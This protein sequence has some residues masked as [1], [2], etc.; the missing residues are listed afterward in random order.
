MNTLAN[1]IGFGDYRT[2]IDSKNKIKQIL[3][4]E[5]QFYALPKCWRF[6]AVLGV[7]EHSIIWR[8]QSYLRKW[9]YH[10]NLHHRIRTWFYKYKTTKLGNKHHIFISPNCI[11][12]GLKIFHLGNIM[13]NGKAKIGKNFGVH[14]G[15][16]IVATNGIDKAAVIG[17][18]CR[19]G[20]GAILVG[21][22]SLGNNIVVGAGSIVTKSFNVNH[23]TLAGVPAK[24]ISDKA[25]I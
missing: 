7:S 17:D 9:E 4:E 10:L 20:V 6:L 14:I 25:E 12:E 18:N 23:V 22:I 2:M 15:V 13:I 11:D 1:A 16:S 19:I 8:Y 21:G 5:K 3:R 24:V